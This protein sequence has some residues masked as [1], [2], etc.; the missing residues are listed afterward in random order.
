MLSDKRNQAPPLSVQVYTA[1]DD[2]IPDF[3]R[4]FP[5]GQA[6][7]SEALEEEIRYWDPRFP[8]LIDAPPGLGKTTF[9]IKTLLPDAAADGK[10]VLFISSRVAISAQTK[11]KALEMTGEPILYSDYGIQKTEIFDHLGI[12]TYARLSGFLKEEKYASWIREIRYVVAD[13]CHSLV[14]ESS[15]NRRCELNLYLLTSRF[16]HAVKIYMSAT[17]SDIL[18]PLAQAEQSNFH[19]FTTLVSPSLG[20]RYC[21]HYLFP[22]DYSHIRLRFFQKT[23]EILDLIQEKPDEKFLIFTRSKSKGQSLREELGTDRADYLDADHKGSPIWKALIE[24]N[25]FSRQVLVTT[26]VL[27]EGANVID[28]ALKNVVLFTSDRSSVIQMLGRKR[29]APGESF[30]LYVWDVPDAILKRHLQE[31]ER[32]NI[33]LDRYNASNPDARRNLADEIWCSDDYALQHYFQLSGGSL[34]PNTCAFHKLNRQMKLCTDI[35]E[36]RYCFR[37]AVCGWLGKVYSKTPDGYEERILEFCQT[38]IGEGIDEDTLASLRKLV[39]DWQDSMGITEDQPTRKTSMG[40]IALTTRLA[41][42]GIPYGIKQAGQLFFI[43]HKVEQAVPETTEQM[44]PTKSS[45][46]IK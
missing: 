35:L 13:E 12:I 33:Y 24:Q 8:V 27:S 21:L 28:P 34:F 37:E 32:L 23:Q 36:G 15:F 14:T 9:A 38:H 6:R 4:T 40:A 5:C 16:R 11:K 19:D 43:Y 22:A 45:G 26:S 7:I 39:M 20:T 29:C 42:H 10:N 25:T 2:Y 18:V 3:Y 30:T 46:E 44:Q 31:A 41:D 1:Y 17:C